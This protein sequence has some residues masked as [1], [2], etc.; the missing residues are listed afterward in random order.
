MIEKI[1]FYKIPIWWRPRV[2]LELLLELLC[3]KFNLELK[4]DPRTKHGYSL[5]NDKMVIFIRG[6]FVDVL[7]DTETYE[8]KEK[9]FNRLFY[10]VGRKRN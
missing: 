1:L 2:I 5:N 10:E 3:I 6:K 4:K 7:L 9:Y 8:A